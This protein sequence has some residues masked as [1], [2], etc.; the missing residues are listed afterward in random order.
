MLVSVATANFYFLPFEETLDIIAEAGFHNIELDLYWEWNQWA[1]AQH[2]K[3]VSVSQVI[4][5][6]DQSGLQVSSI[7]DGGG[8][9]L[10]PESVK[11]YI[12]PRLDEYLD[13]LGYVPTNLVF[14]TPHIEGKM[15]TTW[16]G[17][18]SGKIVNAL[19]PYRVFCHH[20]TLENMP[21]FE[22]F[23]VPLNTPQELHAFVIDNG[24]GVTF[25]TT[26]YAYINLDLLW[27][28]RILQGRI[29]SV[30]L[31]DFQS[32]KAHV[33][34]GE[35]SLPL[36]DFLSLVNLPCLDA[37]TLECSVSSI[38]KTDREMNHTEIVN[39][40]KLAKEKVENLLA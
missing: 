31:S 16:W 18:L 9:L 15:N 30:H 35:G 3:D 27:A 26:H 37:V 39:R 22:G 20:I 40:L 5:S 13:R 17:Q 25:D 34:V 29:R 32:G 8:V 7:H 6:I 12:N 19:D 38:A 14:H 11:G 10:H 24:F 2:L 4:H 28:A 23:T 1:M 21:A 36:A 33:F